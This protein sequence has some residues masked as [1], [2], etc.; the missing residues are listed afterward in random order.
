[1]D[2]QKMRSSGKIGG[3]VCVFLCLCLLSVGCVTALAAPEDG[4]MFAGETAHPD[5]GNPVYAL[6]GSTAPMG[7]AFYTLQERVLFRWVPGEAEPT[8]YCT[9]PASPPV[10][11]FANPGVLSADV[12]EQVSNAVTQ[13]A[14]GD[15]ALWAFNDFAMR[16]G[17]V[18]ESGVQWLPVT[19]DRSVVSPDQEPFMRVA[20]CWVRDGQFE[21][22]V[23]MSDYDRGEWR[24]W[25]VLRFDLE[26]GA[27]S[28]VPFPGAVMVCP[29]KPGSYLA[30]T[31][32][33][34]ESRQAWIGKLSAVDGDTG[35]QTAL[36]LEIAGADFAIGGLCYDELVDRICYAYQGEIWSS[37]AG[38][39]FE[40][41]G[42]L[43]VATVEDAAEAWLLHGDLYAIATYGLY[44]RIITP[45]NKP[46]RTLRLQGVGDDEPYRRF[47][48]AYPNVPAIIVDQNAPSASDIANAIR[49][50]TSDVDV[51]ALNL[52]RSWRVLIEKDF[53]A[54]LSASEKLVSDVARM[55]PHLQAALCD[56]D[57][58][59][60]GYPVYLS[61]S[62]WAVDEKLWKR[63]DMGPL[64]V[65]YDQLLDYWLRWDVEFS[66]DNPEIAFL[67]GGYDIHSV[68][69]LII[70]AYIYRY[71]QPGQPLDI[72]VPLLY[73]LLEKVERLDFG[74]WAER[75]RNG[76][77]NDAFNAWINRPALFRIR[78]PKGLL[79]NPVG[80]SFYALDSDDLQQ[81]ND[82]NS[83]PMLPPV[84]VEG[85]DPIFMGHA[86]VL[87][88]NPASRSLDL[89]LAF[90]EGAVDADA[91][92]AYLTHPDLN[93]PLESLDFEREIKQV[94]SWRAEDIARLD[95]VTNPLGRKDVLA[96]IDYYD[97][98]LAEAENNKWVISAGAIPIARAFMP[99]M[100][101]PERSAILH[102]EGGGR[103]VLWGLIMRYAQGQLTLDDFLR[104]LDGKLRMM[105]LEGQ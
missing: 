81:S 63:F 68:T 82:A 57:G 17:R 46:T 25:A 98:W 50:G 23:D 70:E 7:G 3:M 78:T 86:Q 84:F 51:Y 73:G 21:Y 64:P 41:V 13:I 66:A 100:R 12:I 37:V 101:L 34:D 45:E 59:L 58:K 93:E 102:D 79:N 103:E 97:R 5:T 47:A 31:A 11:R 9:F 105:V 61:A 19:L 60:M 1:M 30:Y 36:P 42:Y 14:G 52:D 87:F 44:T 77:V 65:T 28:M 53:T 33:Y 15:G 43:P 95:V 26:T 104:E 88:A 75:N 8:R 89:A 56:E 92:M 90:I 35:V 85:E 20:Y 48:K 91:E 69:Y 39:P 83:A 74:D 94:Q 27:G 18:D 99:H 6:Q 76:E 49:N 29:Y 2:T 24:E 38:A 16:V 32:R 62:P 67:S 40:S 71:E 72:A 22:L 55:Y 10:P 54:D 4:A 80:T 96:R